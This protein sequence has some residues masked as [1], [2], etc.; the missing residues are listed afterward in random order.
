MTSVPALRL[1][2]ILPLGDGG[3]E[4]SISS[5]AGTP[6]CVRIA[7]A[8]FAEDDAIVCISPS[9][10]VPL[11]SPPSK[12]LVRI[13]AGVVPSFL[14]KGGIALNAVMRSWGVAKP[15]VAAVVVVSE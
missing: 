10:F 11:A 9:I 5:I 6:M 3:R 14:S 15:E 2:L 13:G 8:R 1:L 7:V 12:Y 4:A